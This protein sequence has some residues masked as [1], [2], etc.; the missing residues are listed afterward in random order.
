MAISTETGRFFVDV[1]HCGGKPELRMKKALVF[2]SA[3]VVIAVGVSGARYGA[4]HPRVQAAEKPA[5]PARDNAAE[6][7]TV[8]WPVYG[9]QVADD[10]Y[11]PL[12]QINRE[13]V[14]RLRVAWTFDTKEKNGLQTSPLIV[15]R[16]LYGLTPTQKVIALDA[17]TGKL[18]WTFDSG[19]KGT[20]P[21]RGLS[22][23]TDGSES[24]LFAGVMNFLYALDPATGKPIP[25]FGENGR[26]DLRKGIRGDYR[27]QSI[28]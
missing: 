9:G 11:S 24:R 1:D 14:S 20:Q 6:K 13:N 18:L 19:M 2:A 10:H 22:W 3:L 16:V 27:E 25:T 4:M 26:I 28:G 12:T 23:W 8:D 15:G 7:R 21:D 5:L 17:A